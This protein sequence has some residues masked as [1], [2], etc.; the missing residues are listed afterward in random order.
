MTEESLPQQPEDTMTQYQS[1]VKQAQPDQV[2]ATHAAALSELSTAKQRS[3]F[4]RL[5]DQLVESGQ[6]FLHGSTGTGPGPGGQ[7]GGVGHY[8]DSVLHG[9]TGTGPSEGEQHNPVGN[10]FD[11]FLH[12]HTG[13]HWHDPK[14][15]DQAGQVLGTTVQQAEH[16]QP[17]ILGRIFGRRDDDD[18]DDTPNDFMG[19]VLN[20]ASRQNDEQA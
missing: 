20:H 15:V 11:S 5:R 12:G 19:R 16:A 14:Q 6:A 1:Y 17:G 3:I 9:H 13:T 4:G 7:P 2:A 10:I 8:Y 18:D